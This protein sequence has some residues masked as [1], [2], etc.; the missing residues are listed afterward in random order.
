MNYTKIQF[1][2]ITPDAEETIPIYDSTIKET[3]TY[4]Y[5]LVKL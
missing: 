4:I 5:T 1:I 3:E 2:T